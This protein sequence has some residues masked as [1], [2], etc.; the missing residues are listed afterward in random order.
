MS[1]PIPESVPTSAD[2]RSK[3][4]L[5]RRALTPVSEQA[6][7]IQTLFKDP[8][9]DL[10][11]PNP[12][13]P[14]SSNSLSAPPEI[15]ANV[16]GSSAGAGSGEF[17]VYKASRRREYE[18]VKLMDE[19]LRREK[20]DEEYQR[21]ME[22]AKRKDEEKTDKNRKRREKRKATKKKA[23]SGK[24]NAGGGEKMD[25]DG[26]DSKKPSLPEVKVTTDGP[27]NGNASSGEPP[28]NEEHTDPGV[29]IYDED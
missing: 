12:S 15:V 28:K 10:K 8:T 26:E 1:E 27:A 9:K 11:L 13:K 24:Q 4:P 21:K 22:E 20:A 14:R 19:E 5:K 23:G 2:P 3:R 17:H 6:T 29:I 18:R 25:V 16:Q 7:E